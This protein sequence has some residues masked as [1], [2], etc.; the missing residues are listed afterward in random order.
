LNERNERSGERKAG[1]KLFHGRRIGRN[2][3]D[4]MEG[5]RGIKE[6]MDVRGKKEVGEGRGDGKK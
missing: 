5:G 1:G 6:G 3:G 4:K 2:E